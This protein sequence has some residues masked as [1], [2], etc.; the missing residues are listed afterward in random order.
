[1]QVVELRRHCRYASELVRRGEGFLGGNLS[2]DRWLAHL[3]GQEVP[4]EHLVFKF[5]LRWVYYEP[6]FSGRNVKAKRYFPNT[7]SLL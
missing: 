6:N 1:M 7:L 4:K 5:I 3:R 2:E